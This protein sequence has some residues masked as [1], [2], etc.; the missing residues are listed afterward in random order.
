MSS[1]TSA[2]ERI[3]TSIVGL[4]LAGFLRATDGAL[5]LD[6]VVSES[7][8]SRDDS[9]HALVAIDEEH[10]EIHEGD[11]Y[12]IEDVVAL[13]LNAVFDMQWTTDD[14]LEWDH[15]T[16]ELNCEAETEWFIYEGATVETPGTAVTPRNNNRNYPDAA[17]S[18]VRTIENSSVAN[19]NLDTAVVGATELAHG[20]VGAGR[21]GGVI[22]RG[23]EI[24]LKQNTTYCF[25]AIA[26]AAGYINFYVGFYQHEDLG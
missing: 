22:A 7:L 21:N 23:R 16:F 1:I 8:F 3:K 17:N 14:I 4:P 18:T 19:A 13:A 24:V 2:I 9:T 6:V 20:I 12:F 15:F 11:R 10:N 5:K 26:N 25:R